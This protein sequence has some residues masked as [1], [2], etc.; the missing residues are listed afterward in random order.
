MT[1]R[2]RR[3]GRQVWPVLLVV[4]GLLVV[5]LVNHAR[6]ERALR[7]AP[8]V[9]PPP[10]AAR[11]RPLPIE[12]T[13]IGL[14]GADPLVFALTAAPAT[15]A[16]IDTSDPQ[17][18]PVTVP[19]DPRTAWI[20]ADATTR[21]VWTLA[22]VG[23]TTQVQRFDP[24]GL[25]MIATVT[26][27]FA[28]ERAAA[29]GGYLWVAAGHTV[30]R[31]A[32]SAGRAVR[33]FEAAGSVTALAADEVSSQIVV[34]VARGAVSELTRL[35]SDTGHPLGRDEVAA[36]NLSLAPGAPFFWAAGTD[37]AGRAVLLR[38][39]AGSTRLAVVASAGYP[40]APV[41][42]VYS[43]TRGLWV[44]QGDR[45]RCADPLSGRALAV[46]A[47][48]DGPVVEA[49]GSVF[50]L[51]SQTVQEWRATGTGCPV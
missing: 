16:R 13:A 50:T 27:P 1:Q 47:P 48:V 19:V 33:V 17:A 26:V 39:I 36:A 28:V 3:S 31:L 41:I 4:C 6:A 45:L 32:E 43:G 35:D 25:S 23:R 34:A 22:A 24:L 29:F 12:G 2:P 10:A 46:V 21:T 37:R 20:L 51:G 38:G 8:V 49:A 7:P 9:V 14:A 15:L 42:T 30:Y 11:L 5:A 18:P 44:A 40:S